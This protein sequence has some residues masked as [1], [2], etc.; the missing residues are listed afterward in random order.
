MPKTSDVL[1]PLVIELSDKIKKNAADFAKLQQEDKI[2]RQRRNELVNQLAEIQ[3][4]ERQ[5]KR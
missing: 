2:L 5:S 1:K 3:E 4:T